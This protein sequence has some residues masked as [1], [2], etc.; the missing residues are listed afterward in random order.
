M[1]D[2]RVHRGPHPEDPELF[3]GQWLGP[4]QRATSELC[5]LLD[6]DY[7]PV[8]ALKLVGDRYQLAQRQRIAVMRC[9]CSRDAA[10]QRMKRR[11]S[12]SNLAGKTLWI[13]GYNVLT[14][15]EAALGGGVLL[16]GRDGCLRDM[17]SMHGTFR[18]V[19]ETLP[20]A[21]LVGEFCSRSKVEKCIWLLDSPVSNSGRLKTTLRQIAEPLGWNWEIDLVPDP[22]RI[23]GTSQGLVATAD[24][25]ILDRCQGW[26]PLVAQIVH[27]ELSAKWIVDLSELCESIDGDPAGESLREGK[28]PAEP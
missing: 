10:L 20:A 19:A 23:L 9:S 17:C 2:K 16:V 4:L 14:T 24:S 15:L 6:R 5:W 1:P 18:K 12:A 25:V 13:D 8:S 3:G 21:K 26:F 27:S 28:A 11:V 22:D 7:S